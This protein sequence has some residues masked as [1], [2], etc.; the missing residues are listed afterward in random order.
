MN[1]LD[2]VPFEQFGNFCFEDS[3]NDSGLTSAYNSGAGSGFVLS[4]NN[5]DLE[6]IVSSD[7]RLDKLM[8]ALESIDLPLQQKRLRA[9][10]S[11]KLLPSEA[12]PEDARMEDASEEEKRRRKNKEQVLVLQNEYSRSQNWSRQFMK[13]LAKATGLKTAQVYKWHWDQRKKE[14]DE[15]RMRQF[16]YPNQIFQVVDSRGNNIAKPVF[17][18][19]VINKARPDEEVDEPME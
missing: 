17:H 13:E 15:K 2:A 12:K 3:T 4:A 5:S 7:E 18:K 11:G 14:A 1:G 6:E 9:K 10:K 19:F 16:F 8:A